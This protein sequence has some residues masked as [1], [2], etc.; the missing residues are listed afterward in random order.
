[1]SDNASV[2]DGIIDLELNFEQLALNP[3]PQELLS[4]NNKQKQKLRQAREMFLFPNITLGSLW[5]R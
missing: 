2:D 3:V 1:M 5:L 4:L